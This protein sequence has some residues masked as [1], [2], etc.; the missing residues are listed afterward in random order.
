MM[1][2]LEA[3]NK[4]LE[5]NKHGIK[6]TLECGISDTRISI[7]KNYPG[8]LPL[9]LEG[10]NKQETKWE[11]LGMWSPTAFEWQL[12]NWSVTRTD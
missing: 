8:S 2:L 5:L 11:D 1:H 12:Q 7:D 9:R 3:V 4:L 10:L 6:A